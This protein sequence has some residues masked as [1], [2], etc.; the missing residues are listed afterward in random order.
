MIVYHWNF[1]HVKKQPCKKSFSLKL[2]KKFQVVKF[3]SNVLKTFIN[4]LCY[5]ND[6]DCD[7]LKL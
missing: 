6:K 4:T 5:N 2:S 1:A 3:I 7:F